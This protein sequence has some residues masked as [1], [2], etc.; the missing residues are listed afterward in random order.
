MQLREHDSKYN[1]TLG[2][3]SVRFD[4]YLRDFAHGVTRST[5]VKDAAELRGVN[6]LRV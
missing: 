2:I 4:L 1:K 3:A 6:I 5:A